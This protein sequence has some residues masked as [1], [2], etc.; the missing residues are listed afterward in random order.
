MFRRLKKR[1]CDLFEG[2]VK[3]Y[4]R[5]G[6]LIWT[7]SI[8]L[9]GSPGDVAANLMP[10]TQPYSKKIRPGDNRSLSNIL[11]I[12]SWLSLFDISIALRTTLSHPKYNVILH[13]Y[14]VL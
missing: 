3:W 9:E 1:L 2:P 10:R 5:I 7:G 11:P 12:C 8:V 13:I 14:S 4:A 6:C